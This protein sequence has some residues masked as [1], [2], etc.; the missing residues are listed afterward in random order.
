VK[1]YPEHDKLRGVSG[2]SQAIG[3]FVDWLGGKG[4]ILAKR[5]GED[6]IPAGTRIQALLAEFFEIDE[7]EIEAEKRVMLL[8]MRDANERPA[9]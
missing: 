6:L 8:E 5:Q 3:E 1:K 9:P 4:I 7:D 2:K